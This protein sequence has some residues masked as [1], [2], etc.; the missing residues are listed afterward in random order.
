MYFELFLRIFS[1]CC[2]FFAL[3]GCCPSLLPYSYPLLLAALICGVSAA[4]SSFL[5]D[6]GWKLIS[7]ICALLPF[8][9]L[10]LADGN[11]REMVILV[12]PVLYTAFVTFQGQIYL[13]YFSYRKFFI[14]SLI[15]LGAIWAAMSIGVYIEDPRGIYEKVIFTETILQYTLV[16]FLCGIVLQRQLRLGARSQ[17]HGEAGQLVGMLGSA[18][19]VAAGF[20]LTESVVR[21]GALD[22][23][24]AVVAVLTAPFQIILGF[25]VYLMENIKQMQDSKEYKEAWENSDYVYVGGHTDY[26]EMMDKL[27]EDAPEPGHSPW[28][29]VFAAAAAVVILILMVIAFTKI[30]NP[31]GGAL[32]ISEVRGGEKKKNKTSRLSNRGKVRQAYRE[33]LRHERQHGFRL[34]T[35]YTTEDI[36]RKVSTPENEIPAAQLREVY[37]HARYDEE[38]EVTRSQAEAA[39][40]ALRSIKNSK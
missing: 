27:L 11:A 35:H 26:Q 6:K 20:F 28:I 32:V 31:R 13:E 9:S 36:L 25:I 15:I 22:V 2:I 37:L 33:F 16:H 10:L 38:S 18:G 1:D 7:R 21:D 29:M 3:L 17:T 23:L 12:L 34:K 19:A 4:S 30:M 40:D 5:Y 24:R 39:R 8:L 14:R